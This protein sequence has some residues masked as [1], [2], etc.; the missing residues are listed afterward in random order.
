MKKKRYLTGAAALCAGLLC[1]V[2]AGCSAGVKDG[3]Y[4]ARY[5][6][7]SNGYVEYLTVTFQNGKPS[8]AEFDAYLESDPQSRKSQTSKEEYPMQPHPSQWMPQLSKNVTAAG[9]NPDKIATVAGATNS[10][11]HA[12]ELYD[13]ILKAAEKGEKN[14]IIVENDAEWSDTASSGSSASSNAAGGSSVPGG[15]SVSDANGESSTP[16]SAS[17][18]TI[19]GESVGSSDTDSGE[20]GSGSSAEDSSTG[21]SGSGTS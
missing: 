20:S 4:T 19:P 10:S 18:E 9:T 17:G 8:G 21:G 6:Y 7:P 3:T 2:L 16:Q 15:E 5:R 13:A 14:E 11:R 1:G 12:R